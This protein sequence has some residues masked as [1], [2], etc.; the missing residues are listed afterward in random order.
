MKSGTKIVLGLILLATTLVVWQL[1]RP[2]PAV[3][4]T[5]T[6]PSYETQ[7]NT[8]GEV[9]VSV[10]PVTLKPGFPPSFDIAFE[11]HSVDLVFDVKQI[12]MLTDEKNTT[13]TPVWQGS[14]P[15][16]HHRSGTLRFTPD[17]PK[18]G[19]VTLTLSS[20]AGISARTFTWNVE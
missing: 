13:Y 15:G 1:L 12:A 10:T 2:S 20:I 8:G 11:T 4:S 6:G 14:P 16:G 17:L 18:P 3:V 19:T 9:E 5:E 7:K